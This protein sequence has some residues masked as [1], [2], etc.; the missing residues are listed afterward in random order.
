MSVWAYWY[1]QG[2]TWREII[3]KSKVFLNTVTHEL[4]QQQTHRSTMN[5]FLAKIPKIHCWKDNLSDWQLE[6]Y[7]NGSSISL[8]VQ[9][10]AQT[11]LN[12]GA[13][14]IENRNQ[15]NKN[16]PVRS[17]E[18]HACL[19]PDLRMQRQADLCL[20]KFEVSLVYLSSSRLARAT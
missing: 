11:G 3:S 17:L 2:E 20:C 10:S 19:I 1:C 9:E 15:I 8:L 6:K 14:T 5:S 13:N 7:D 18:W 16:T 4:G 12:K